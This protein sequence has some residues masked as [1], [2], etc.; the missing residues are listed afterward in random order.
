MSTGLFY[1]GI[2]S[3]STP[4]E[5][6]ALMTSIATFLAE[7]QYVLRSG[8]AIGADSAF[9]SGAGQRRQIFLP[10][11][12]YNQKTSP[13]CKVTA[14][15]MQTVDQY[16]PAPEF[17][18]PAAK[19]L[20]ARNSYQVLG[21]D[22]KT[23][24]RFVVCWTPDGCI[25]RAGRTKQTGGTGQ[26]IT[27]A[28]ANGIEIINLQRHDHLEFILSRLNGREVIQDIAKNFPKT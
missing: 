5:I 4:V 3:R 10:W 2:G 15:A 22:L 16:H 18:T 7:R 21:P 8:G 19:K 17:L 9:E 24:S 26:A 23:P 6:L 27:I 1:A 20:M 13:Y 14:P 28:E 25:D 11:N 12:G